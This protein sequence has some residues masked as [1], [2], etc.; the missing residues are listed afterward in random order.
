MTEPDP[1]RTHPDPARGPGLRAAVVALAEDAGRAILEV[2]ARDFE[3]SLKDDASPL[4]EADLASHRSIVAGLAR[5]TPALPVLSEEAVDEAPFET[6]RAWRRFWLV[7]PLDGTKEFV[8]RN[9]EFTVNI[10]LIEDGRPVLGVV[11]APVLGRS[12]SA[13]VGEGAWRHAADAPP[14]HLAVASPPAATRRVVASRSHAG[15]ETAALLDTLRQEGP[16]D[17]VSRGSSLKFCLVAEGSAELYPRLGPTM[18]WD[19]AAAHCVVEQA[20]G[21]VVELGGE[22]LRYNKPSL[23]NP[24]FV[25]SAAA[26]HPVLAHLRSA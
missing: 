3:V 2:Y 12:Y 6:R 14:T 13:R 19:T 10:A 1:S 4:T 8:K 20:G 24:W 26:P 16:L 7:D 21:H 23:L 5:L 15:S 18:E 25:V 11:H 17:V 9:G 22:P